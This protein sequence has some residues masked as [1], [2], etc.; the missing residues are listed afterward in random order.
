MLGAAHA[1][2]GGTLSTALYHQEPGN[3]PHLSRPVPENARRGEQVLINGAS[4]PGV[5]S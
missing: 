1:S 3:F 2:W 5:L 4:P